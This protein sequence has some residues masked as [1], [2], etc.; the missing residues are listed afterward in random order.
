MSNF[1]ATAVPIS[2]CT[3]FVASTLSLKPWLW[4]S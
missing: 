4:Q 1:V 2:L 3:P